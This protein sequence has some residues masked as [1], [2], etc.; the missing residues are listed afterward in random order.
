MKSQR[1]DASPPASGE[2]AKEVKEAEEVS[3]TALPDT[4]P[5]AEMTDSKRAHEIENYSI[6]EVLKIEEPNTSALYD[7]SHTTSPLR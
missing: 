6:D 5:E 1:A 2:I 7:D 4:L 3:A